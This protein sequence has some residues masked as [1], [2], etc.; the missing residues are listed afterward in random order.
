MIRVIHI[1][2]I[3]ILIISCQSAKNNSQNFQVV[4]I[5]IDTSK[6]E[7]I[8]DERMLALMLVDFGSPNQLLVTDKHISL[9]NKQGDTILSSTYSVIEQTASKK[10]M[11]AETDTLVLT[12]TNKHT[13][14]LNTRVINYF[15]KH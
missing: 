11:I 1:I 12:Y 8:A 5:A 4:D 13:A 9:F 2:L 14:Q 10:V 3:G 15:L 6:I 7:G